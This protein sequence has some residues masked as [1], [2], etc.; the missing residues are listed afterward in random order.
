[1]IIILLAVTLTAVLL[2][3]FCS[4]MEAALLAVP[5]AHVKHLSDKNIKSG[6]I[7]MGF[8]ADMGA[9]I[10]AILILNTIS[11]TIGAAV[12][13][14]IVAREYDET[15]VV[16]YSLIF[17]GLILFFSEIIPK[18]LGATHPK[19]ISSYIAKPL[20]FLTKLLAPLICVTS[21]VSKKFSSSSEPSV[22][23]DEVLSMAQLGNEEGVIDN[24][25]GSVIRN[26]IGLDRLLVKNILT[27]RV[28]VFRIEATTKVKEIK[29]DIPSWNNTRVPLFN[30]GDNDSISGYVIQ[31]DI[32]RAIVSDEGEKTLA[33]LSRPLTIVSEFMRADKLLLQMFEMGETIC[34]VIDE[35]GAFTGIVTVEDII[36]EI[37]GREI[38]DEYDLVSDLRTYARVLNQKSKKK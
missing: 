36:E 9:P 22:S 26:I 13:G 15:A 24:L 3:A 5:L 1:M 6:K 19:T 37:V 12:A 29:S 25:E 28:V 4:L 11:N 18:H 17:T 34:S 16:I 35:H 23:E 7:L 10:S 30:D 32:Y 31:R 38:V 27:P 14:A 8:K 20:L 33:E 2:S 21:L